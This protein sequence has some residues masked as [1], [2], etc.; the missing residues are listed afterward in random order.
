MTTTIREHGIRIPIAAGP[1]LGGVL[2]IPH[3]V[4]EKIA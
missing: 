2:A 1:S 4:S 3:G